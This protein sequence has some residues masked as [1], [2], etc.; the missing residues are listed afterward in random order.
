M[1]KIVC[2]ILFILISNFAFS[3]NY[4]NKNETLVFS[5]T[6]KSGKK[7]VIAKRLEDNSIIYRFGTTKKIEM[8][9]VGNKIGNDHKMYYSYYLRGG[10]A[11]NEGMDL[12][13]VHFTKAKITYVVYDTYYAM[14]NTSKIGIKVIDLS[15]NKT[16]DISGDNKTRKGSLTDFRDNQLLEMSEELFD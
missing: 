12:N 5:F 10:G 7:L 4:L 11:G 13:Y 9:Y 14:D 2:L 3:Q 8:E 15:T 1:N 16:T 6:T